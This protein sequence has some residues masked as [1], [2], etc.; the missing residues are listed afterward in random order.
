MGSQKKSGAEKANRVREAEQE[1]QTEHAQVEHLLIFNVLSPGKGPI[2]TVPAPD[3]EQRCTG[4]VFDQGP[5]ATA[6][7]SLGLARGE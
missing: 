3:V 6:A 4:N 1:V 7:R 5:F 2:E